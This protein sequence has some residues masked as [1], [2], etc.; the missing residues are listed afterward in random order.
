MKRILFSVIVT[1]GSFTAAA[2]VLAGDPVGPANYYLPSYVEHGHCVWHHRQSPPPP[3]PL[4]WHCGYYDVEWGSPVALVVPPTTSR[5]R[6]MGWGVG[7][8][9][10]RRIGD[11]FDRA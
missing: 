5:Y 2:T 8:T 4:P 11:Q 1:L 7:N 3:A 10:M 6:E 9:R